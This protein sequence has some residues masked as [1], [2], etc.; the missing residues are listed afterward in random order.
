MKK[1]N[2]WDQDALVEFYLKEINA[3]PSSSGMPAV[4][5]LRSPPRAGTGSPLR[6]A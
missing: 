3:M 2:E 5:R 4:N 6:G 1:T